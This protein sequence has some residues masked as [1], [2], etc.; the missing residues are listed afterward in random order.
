MRK[1]LPFTAM[2]IVLLLGLVA[3]SNSTDSTNDDSTTPTPLYVANFASA[4][5]SA[6]T[7]GSGGA[8]SA[9]SL[10]GGG[11]TTGYGP[12]GIAITPN[13][14]YLYVV[15]S[16]DSE[17]N[18]LC[19]YSIG[20]DGA[21]SALSTASYTTGLNPWGI[22]IS[23]N[24]SYLYVTNQGSSGASGLSAYSIGSGGALSPITLSSAGSTTGSG[25]AAIAISPNGSYLYVTN[26]SSTG[27][28]GL[29]A[30]SIGSGGALS[31][32]TLSGAGSTT[33][34]N[35]LGIAISPN[36]IYLYLANYGSAALSAYSIGSGGGL[37]PI[38]SGPFSTGSGPQGIAISPNGSYLYVANSLDSEEGG[39]SAYAIGSGGALSALATYATGSGPVAIAI[40]P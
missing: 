34:S 1:M 17:A 40:A 18:G 9:I 20:S 38:T 32:I 4:T 13:G 24:G 11:S 23:P 15:N 26:L 39:L 33:G 8:L 22:A 2:A 25:P 29:C 31:A 37:S 30:Y 14:S 16:T 6:Y 19:A 5:L 10:S 7:V 12:T 28:N 21:L 36:G 3:C 27:A 35:P